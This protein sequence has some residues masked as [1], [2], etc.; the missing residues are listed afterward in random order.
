M[1]G[2]E[3]NEVE[4]E[5]KNRINIGWAYYGRGNG[6]SITVDREIS[7]F[8][9]QGI[10][11]EEYFVAD[12]LESSFFLVTDFHFEKILKIKSQLEIYPGFE[13]GS[14]D[15]K[16]EIHSYLGISLPLNSKIGMYTELG[17]RGV[18]G[19]YAKF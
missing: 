10:G 13:Y 16:F 14:F 2:Q 19:L 8:I 9:S 18:F 7:E 17:T 1:Q 6:T 4:K 12:E 3:F 5:S 11:V 15:R